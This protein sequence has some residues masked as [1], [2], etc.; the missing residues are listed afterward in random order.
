MDNG[1]GLVGA[2]I[3][4]GPAP[5]EL[6]VLHVVAGDLVQRA[7]ALALVVAA[8]DEPVRGGWIP[9]HGGR[10]RHVVFHFA[11]HTDA[12]RGGCA[13]TADDGGGAAATTG[14]F[15]DS[16]GS[17]AGGDGTD[18]HGCGGSQWLRTGLR[19]VALQDVRGDVEGRRF[20]ERAGTGGRHGLQNVAEEFAHHFGAPLQQKRA[21][22]KSR[23]VTGALEVGAVATGAVL[24]VYAASGLRLGGGE[25]RGGLLGGKN[26]DDRGQNAGGQSKAS[27]K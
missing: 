24:V 9:Q 5:L 16:G 18:L 26:R 19:A 4:D 15:S 23:R 20:R 6:Q 8:K 25:R 17:L 22:G 14:A 1:R 21:A 11:L 13:G 2:G 27:G 12:A 7:V 10:D 3:I